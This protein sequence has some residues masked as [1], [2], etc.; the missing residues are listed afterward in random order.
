MYRHLFY[1]Q[2]EKE[3][4][5]INIDFKTMKEA[6]EQ[7]KNKFFWVSCKEGVFEN[8]DCKSFYGK[9]SLNNDLT[10]DIS[11]NKA[12]VSMDHNGSLRTITFYRSC[13]RVDAGPGFWVYKDYS[14]NGPFSFS[15]KIG[16]DLYKLSDVDWSYRTSFL[17]N[18]FPITEFF[19]DKMKVTLIVYTPISED[20]EQRLSGAVYGIFVENTSNKRLAGS[21]KI[22]ELL[23]SNYKSDVEAFCNTNVDAF[24]DVVDCEVDKAQ[25]IIADMFFND[26]KNGLKEVSFDLEPGDNIWV[27]VVICAT[28]EEETV[29]KVSELGSLYWLNSTWQYYR[30]LS[31]RLIM[32]DDQFN[33]EFF[34]RAVYQSM[35]VVSMDS[36]GNIIG[37]ENGT[38]TSLSMYTPKRVWLKDSYYYFLPFCMFDPGFYAKAI[39]WYLQYNIRH[40]GVKFKGGIKHSL[41]IAL[42]PVVMSGLYYTHTGDKEFFINNSYIKER[43]ISLLEQVINLREKEDVWLFPSIWISDL[44]SYGDYNTGGNLIAWYSFKAFARIL[45]EVYQDHETAEKYIQIAN[46]IRDDIESHNIIDG[47]FGKQYIEGINIDGT[48][49]AMIHECEESDTTIMPFYGYLEYDDEIFKNY[50]RFALSEYNAHYNPALKGIGY[51]PNSGAVFSGYNT[52]LANVVDLETMNGE[53]GYMTEIRRLT[54]LDGSLWWYPYLSETGEITYGNVNRAPCKCVWGKALYLGL[55]VPEFLGI[56]YDAPTRTLSFRPFSPSGDFTWEDFRMGYDVFSVGYKRTINEVTANVTNKNGHNINLKLEILL[57]EKKKAKEILVNGKNN[58]ISYEEGVF[59]KKPTVKLLVN[60]LPN[61][62]S[63][64]I[65]AL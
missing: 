16:D 40:T 51:G 30:N 20:G 9:L 63:V 60:L 4:I 1:K 3:V 34:H 32:P 12:L 37:S 42:A 56:K 18:I 50:T 62:T 11:N 8:G 39:L 19:H 48:I 49:P 43:S 10:F 21:V 36:K 5:S 61:E 52:G 15:I 25:E 24:I 22:P 64:I 23:D 27:P 41:T 38:C 46:K 47:P 26:Y 13:Y 54:D 7:S 6:L 55:F 31:G 44:P 59:L 29:T 33:E 58:D 2:Q 65:V 17:D 45:E 14:V 28:A 35:Q 57:D 53:N